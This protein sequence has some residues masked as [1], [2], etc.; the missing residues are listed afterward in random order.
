MHVT[1]KKRQHSTYALGIATLDL[2]IINISSATEITRIANVQF[3]EVK[4]Q[5]LLGEHVPGTTL[6]LLSG[7][8]EY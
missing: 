6:L 8:R 4:F 3:N 5:I 1:R 7:M 2:E